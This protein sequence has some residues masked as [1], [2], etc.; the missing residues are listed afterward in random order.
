MPKIEGAIIVAKGASGVEMK[1]K[2]ASTISSVTGI[3][4]YKV[5]VFEKQ[6]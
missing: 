2:I 4:V 3:P 6:G 5:Q 1:S